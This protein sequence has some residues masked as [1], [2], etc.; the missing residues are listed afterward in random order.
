MGPASARRRRR[1]RSD[2]RM[3]FPSLR[4]RC[5]RCRSDRRIAFPTLRQRCPRCRRDRLTYRYHLHSRCRPSSFRPT[6][7][8]PAVPPVLE[9][10]CRWCRQRS[11]EPPVAVEP[12]TGTIHPSRWNRRSWTSRHCLRRHHCWCCC[13]P[14][15]LSRPNR[16]AHHARWSRLCH[17]R[18]R[19]IP[20]AHNRRPDEASPGP[21]RMDEN[22]GP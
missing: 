3:P 1:C 18:P 9:P 15:P 17:P 12:P 8:F 16:I 6:P 5:R 22:A 4:Q 20:L 21:S 2:R 13:C 19:A 10:P 11:D 14:N 7:P